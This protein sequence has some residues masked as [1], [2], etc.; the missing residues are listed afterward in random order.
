M[1]LT[2][3]GEI[4]NSQGLRGE[5]RV[6]PYTDYKER[7]E[8]LDCLFLENGDKLDIEYVK[9]KKN[10]VILK[11]KGCDK[12]EDV[13]KYKGNDIY[14]NEDQKRE[15]PEGTYHV[16]DLIGCDIF[17]IESNQVIG[18]LVDILQNTAQGIYVI[19][20]QVENKKFMVPCVKEFVKEIDIDSNQIKIKLI[21]GMI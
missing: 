1:Q 20:H 2:K 3:I 15:L 8:E 4:V 11:L 10:M 16:S 21:E 18:S 5:V 14:I 6:Y 19:K 9:Y 17:D 7:F 13:E 12:I